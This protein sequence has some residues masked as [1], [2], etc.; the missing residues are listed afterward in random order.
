M[1]HLTAQKA[2]VSV[3]AKWNPS[4]T[5][6]DCGDA[7]TLLE[8][9]VIIADPSTHSVCNRHRINQNNYQFTFI[10]TFNL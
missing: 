8:L 7:A 4:L 10:D 6:R 1:H 2:W 5:P 9:L 3:V